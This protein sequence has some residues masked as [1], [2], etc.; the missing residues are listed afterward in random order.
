M[1]LAMAPCRVPPNAPKNCTLASASPWVLASVTV[2]ETAPVS[3]RV[4]QVRSGNGA[5]EELSTP[6]GADG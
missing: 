5:P 2:T 6:A 3:V 4:D 1:A